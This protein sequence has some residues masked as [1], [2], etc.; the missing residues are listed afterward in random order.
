M[1]V[2]VHANGHVIYTGPEE[3]DNLP[4]SITV[5][6]YV[7]QWE[8]DKHKNEYGN[9]LKAGEDQD[10]AFE[11]ALVAVKM[12]SDLLE[13]GAFPSAVPD[14]IAKAKELAP[15]AWI[16]KREEIREAEKGA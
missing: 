1:Y 9:L 11:D 2:A 8:R 14:A 7:P 3:I 12:L 16:I 5:V 15:G 13:G 10:E 6:P 4:K